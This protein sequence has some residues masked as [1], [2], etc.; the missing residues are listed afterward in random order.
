[1]KKLLP[2]LFPLLLSGQDQY[3]YCELVGVQKMFSSWKLNVIVDTGQLKAYTWKGVIMDTIDAG[4]EP[5]YR[6]EKVYVTTD[7]NFHEGKQ[8]LSDAKGRFIWQRVQVNKRP[9][10]KLKPM[11]FNSMIDGMNYMGARGWQFVQAYTV[12][13]G[14]YHVYRWLL[15]K[16]K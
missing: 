5:E 6:N 1:M 2:F 9:D 4:E 16:P 7:A 10:T 12:G 8:V 3:K 11:T 14:G 13:D 15:K